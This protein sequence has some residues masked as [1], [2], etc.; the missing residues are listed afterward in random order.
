[1]G[2][3]WALAFVFFCLFLSCNVFLF[4]GAYI[5]FVALIIRLR[6]CVCLYHDFSLFSVMSD[7]HGICFFVVFF[8]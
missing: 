2:E 5:S 1:M 4:D 8:F 7:G 3:A 6:A